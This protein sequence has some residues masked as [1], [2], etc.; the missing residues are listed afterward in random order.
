MGKVAI[1]LSWS[2][3][4]IKQAAVLSSAGVLVTGGTNKRTRTIDQELLML[5]LRFKQAFGFRSLV[6]KKK[7]L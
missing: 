3:S 4:Y 7:R 2:P 1:F 6:G 5:C